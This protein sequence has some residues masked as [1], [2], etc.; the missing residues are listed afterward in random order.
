MNQP[1]LLSLERGIIFSHVV[2]MYQAYGFTGIHSTVRVE[3]RR[4]YGSA[5]FQRPG[6]T[7]LASLAISTK[8]TLSLGRIRLCLED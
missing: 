7:M 1:R 6:V 2:S 3:R 8:L 4:K 5:L